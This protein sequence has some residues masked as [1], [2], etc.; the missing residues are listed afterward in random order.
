MRKRTPDEIEASTAHVK[1]CVW[2]NCGE[3]LD[4]R[5]RVGPLCIRHAYEINS[6]IAEV[7]EIFNRGGPLTGRRRERIAAI[8]RQIL[9]ID[10]ERRGKADSRRYTAG[11][12]YYVAIGDR[13]K[14]GYATSV[15]ERMRSYPPGS[16]LLAVHPGT[17]DL[18]R[19]IHTVLAA[20]RVAGRE[21]YSRTDQVMAHLDRALQDFG[22]PAPN[23]GFE[24][25]AQPRG[26]G[27][28]GGVRVLRG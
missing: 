25:P 22:K 27:S 19:Q 7:E 13:I 28:R 10:R 8:E 2:P 14:I 20:S 9:D 15:R 26:P 4:S 23:Y 11:W 21:W 3:P 1:A 16:N 18:E 5:S 6:C 24:Q 17:P 12:I